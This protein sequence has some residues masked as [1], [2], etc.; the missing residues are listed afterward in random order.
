[1]RLDE[2]LEAMRL[3]V[4][5][6]PELV[7]LVGQRVY[8]RNV[9]DQGEAVYPAVTFHTAG[10]TWDRQIVG[11]Y[12]PVRVQFDVWVRG[13]DQPDRCQRISSRLVVML[14]M[15]AVR[16]STS[17]A[18]FHDIRVLEV[19][20]EARWFPQSNCWVQSSIFEAHVSIM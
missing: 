17:T 11:T 3:R 10:G 4:L 12:N 16:T 20:A 1:M 9:F 5:Q 8:L 15:Q 13:S 14:H 18:C 19:P 7:G 2:H 6:D